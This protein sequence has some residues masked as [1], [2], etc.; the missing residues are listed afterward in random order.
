MDE[1]G[2]AFIALLNTFLSLHLR[3]DEF[4]LKFIKI[5]DWVMKQSRL[6]ENG[7]KLMVNLEHLMGLR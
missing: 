4:R 2:G 5:Y 6:V 3:F 1:L 7:L